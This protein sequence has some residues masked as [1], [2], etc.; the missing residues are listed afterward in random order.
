MGQAQIKLFIDDQ[1]SRHFGGETTVREVVAL[2]LEGLEGEEG[3]LFLADSEEPLDPDAK[4]GEVGI[5]RQGHVH[6][7]RC[8]RVE[9]TVEYAGQSHSHQ[10]PP[11]AKV[12]TVRDWALSQHWQAPI[13]PTQHPKFGLFLA[14]DPNALPDARRIGTYT[15][16]GSCAVTFELALRERPQGG[17]GDSP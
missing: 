8:R 5:D 7:G 15:Q 17:E 10:F 6:A 3:Y 11:T 14:G 1:Q 16:K 2:L 13:D 12:K 9:V 4:L